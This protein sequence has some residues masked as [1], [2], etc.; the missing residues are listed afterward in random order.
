MAVA[1]M[2]MQ[3]VTIGWEIYAQTLNPLNLG[4]A[5]LVQFVPTI[6][7]S[8]AAGA[9]VDRYDRKL[10]VVLSYLL[11]ATTCILL[12]ILP[13]SW[14]VLPLYA[15]LALI[16][17]ARAFN[18][19]ATQA[20][21]PDIVD[22]PSLSR[23][24]ALGATARQAAI[25]AGPA[26]GG[27]G[28]SMLGSGLYIVCTALAITGAVLMAAVRARAVAKLRTLGLGHIFEGVQFVW[29]NPLVLGAVSLTLVIAL[30]AGS[31]AILPIYARDIL[32]IGPEGLGVLRSASALGGVVT[33]IAVSR[34]PVT[35]AVG[36]MIFASAALYGLATLAFSASTSLMLSLLSLAVVGAS[37]MLGNV[38]R[39]TLI[40]LETPDA[41]RG[42]VSSTTAILFSASQEL[43]EF[44]SGLAAAVLGTERSVAL[45]GIGAVLITIFWIRAFPELWKIRRFV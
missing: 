7:L 23:A 17:V 13:P 43:C 1:T 26:L 40:Q 19:P 14:G 35:A 36:P 6:L 3:S 33:A 20:L 34:W 9:A 4:F 10:I 16:G 12:F 24:I 8:L 2:Q 31:T 32:Q 27:L 25:V 18:A 11:I 22:K 29:C 37:D 28:Y 38:V 45:G 42:R 39:L 21:L 41:L 30:F 44:K 15:I 5:G